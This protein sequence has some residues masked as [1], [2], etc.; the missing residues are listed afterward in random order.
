MFVNANFEILS[1]NVRLTKNEKNKRRQKNEGTREIAK[2]TIVVLNLPLNCLHLIN[3]KIPGSGYC[4][5]VHVSHGT[6]ASVRFRIHHQLNGGITLNKK[7]E[8]KITTTRLPP[9]RIFMKK[10]IL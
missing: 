10:K 6:Q 5:L 4:S 8:N 3:R 1:G 7:R 2:G 9:V